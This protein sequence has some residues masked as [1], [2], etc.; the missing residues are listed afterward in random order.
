MNI[1]AVRQ[2]RKNATATIKNLRRKGRGEKQISHDSL[3]MVATEVR[4]LCDMLIK[5]HKLLEA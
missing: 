1:K 4:E 2:S 5:I 3:I